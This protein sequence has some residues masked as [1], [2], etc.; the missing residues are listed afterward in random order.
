MKVNDWTTYL[1]QMTAMLDIELDEARRA[2][3]LLQFTRIAQMAGPLMDFPLDERL[4]VAGV[5]Q[6]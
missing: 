6:A 5:Y 1:N 2:E 4:D 3:L